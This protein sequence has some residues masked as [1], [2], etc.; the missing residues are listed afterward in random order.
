MN[1][2][3]PEKIIL[4]LAGSGL[5]A[6][7]V[8][9]LLQFFGQPEKIL[10]AYLQKDPEFKNILN[11]KQLISLYNSWQ[12]DRLS[13]LEKIIKKHEIRVFS[14]CDPEYPDKLT[15][16]YDPPAFLFYQGDLAVMSRRLLAIV[17][18]R[19]A[20]YEG[21]RAT[22]KIAENLSL[23]GVGIISGF[24]YGIDTAAHTGC[25]RGNSPTIA[26][27]GCGLDV[28]YPAEN[29]KL[30]N[31]VLEKGGLFLSEFIPGEKPLGAHF[32]IR[33]RIISGLSDAVILMEGQLKSGSMTT[34]NHAVD[35]N[36][37]V[38]VY[39]GLPQSIMYSA[40]HRLL[41]E[42]ARYF[43]SAEDILEDMGWLDNNENVRQNNVCS[44]AD[45]K[46]PPAERSV[47][48]ILQPGILSFDQ[49]AEKTGLPAVE[50][51]SLL[52]M[53]QIRGNVEALPGKKYCLKNK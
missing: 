20:S 25:L 16:I 40:N 28:N 7:K 39:P 14:A 3:S 11:E 35:Q 32:P 9:T 2:F 45:E 41:R 42:G 46:M 15:E 51:L 27:V 6:G 12:D 30:K 10:E 23:A 53:L 19:R 5:P 18:S 1:S 24:A 43:T 29:S 22:E 26:V 17:G 13:H 8:M 37:D 44:T 50:L 33:N 31:T 21:I 47:L 52:T 36:K 49:I 38:F 4:W 34:I 48:Q